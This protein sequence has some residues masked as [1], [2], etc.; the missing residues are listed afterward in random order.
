MGPGFGCVTLLQI[1]YFDRQ[2]LTKPCD[3]SCHVND[4]RWKWNER[5]NLPPAIISKV[6]IR[7]TKLNQVRSSWIKYRN[8]HKKTGNQTWRNRNQSKK[9]EEEEEEEKEEEEEEIPLKVIDFSFLLLHFMIMIT[10]FFSLIAIIILFYFL[11]FIFFFVIINFNKEPVNQANWLWNRM[12][13][14]LSTLSWNNS[15]AAVALSL[16][17]G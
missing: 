11:F 3:D 9:G 5:L 2:P 6:W 4:N 7:K 12:A 14:V 17:S 13:S 8:A 16:A 15:L 10:T 1:T